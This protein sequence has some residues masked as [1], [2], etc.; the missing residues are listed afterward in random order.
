MK[1]KTLNNSLIE[2]LLT[3]KSE[4]EIFCFS[5]L[6]YTYLSDR[7]IMYR[8]PKFDYPHHGKSHPVEA[9]KVFSQKTIHDWV[10]IPTITNRTS[11]VVRGH[12]CR[13]RHSDNIEGF[14]GLYSSSYLADLKSL[15]AE[16]NEIEGCKTTR[17]GEAL[18]ARFDILI[19]GNKFEAHAIL[20]PRIPDPVSRDFH[21]FGTSVW[22][23]IEK[24]GSEFCG[25]EISEEVLPLAQ[26]AGLCKQVPYIEELHGDMDAVPGDLIWFWGKERQT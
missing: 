1:M 11:D 18:I 19:D 10:S 2:E 26:A 9:H 12:L 7:A 5:D 16:I 25:N 20:M 8:F 4:D 6:N 3:S 14:K 22:K 13:T 23:W 17:Y 21:K 15:E 24:Q